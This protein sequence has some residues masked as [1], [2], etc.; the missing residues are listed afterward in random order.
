MFGHLANFVNAPN[1]VTLHTHEEQSDRPQNW[2]CYRIF[3]AS[4]EPAV[5]EVH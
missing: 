1:I 3:M 4:P 2:S 5:F